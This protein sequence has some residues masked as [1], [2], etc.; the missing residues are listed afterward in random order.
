MGATFDEFA[1]AIHQ[2][3]T[4]GR[5]GAILGDN[6]KALGPLQIH[7]SYFVDS[8]TLGEYKDC[9]N[10]DFSVRVMRNYLKRYAPKAL[11]NR[12]WEICARTHNGGPRGV[13]IAQTKKYWEKVKK[14]LTL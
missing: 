9:A 13:K 6:G 1:T 10:Y 8:G 5:K 3:E 2:V 7:Y 11:D 4:G 12:N 14:H